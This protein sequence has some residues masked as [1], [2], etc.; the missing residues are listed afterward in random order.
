MRLSQKTRV[1]GGCMQY[2]KKLPFF[3]IELRGSF[4]KGE[5]VFWWS[6]C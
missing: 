4:E 2:N 5:D 1:T 6:G 3:Q